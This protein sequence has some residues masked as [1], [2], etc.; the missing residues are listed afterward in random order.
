MNDLTNDLTSDLTEDDLKEALELLRKK[1]IRDEKIKTGEIKSQKWC[2]KTPEQ[3][4]K[5]MDYNKQKSK[6]I[7]A[8]AKKAIAAGITLND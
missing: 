8:L 2:D 6:E 4:K 3:K 5:Q 1:R 7:R